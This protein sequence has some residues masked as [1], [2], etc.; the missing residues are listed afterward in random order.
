MPAEAFEPKPAA[1]EALEKARADAAWIRDNDG[2]PPAP[3]L[4]PRQTFLAVLCRSA[5]R[6]RPPPAQR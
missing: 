4:R 2:V 1:A 5:P 3:G 6:P